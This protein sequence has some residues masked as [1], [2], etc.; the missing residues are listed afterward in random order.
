MKKQITL[1]TLALITLFFSVFAKGKTSPII[2]ND[3]L[4]NS[5]VDYIKLKDGSVHTYHT[6][7]LV[8]G[9]FV[10]PHL[11]ANG[12][13]KVFADDIV[14]YRTNGQLAVSQHCLKGSKKSNIS[15]DAL[16]GFA[17]RIMQGPV[18]VYARKIHNGTTMVTEY[19]L[20]SNNGPIELCTPAT[21]KTSFG[22]NVA[23]LQI[24]EERSKDNLYN[25]LRAAVEIM[26]TSSMSASNK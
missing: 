3:E 24:F 26:N 2:E 25:R 20:Q 15:A 5:K 9:A 13:E 19:Y 16:P 14:E 4:A 11:L 23:A 7:V 18:N 10:S 1:T 12:K 17:I 21:V 6:L 22:N 8:Q